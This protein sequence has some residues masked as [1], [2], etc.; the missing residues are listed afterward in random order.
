MNVSCDH[1]SEK[2]RKK[3]KKRKKKEKKKKEKK[4]K[5]KEKTFTSTHTFS[6]QSSQLGLK[7]RSKQYRSRQL[8]VLLKKEKKAPAAKKPRE[9]RKQPKYVPVYRV[10]RR[11]PSN[12]T[13][14]RAPK[15]RASLKPGAVVILL[16][17]KYQGRRVVL[18]DVLPSG[19]LLVS[20]PYRINGVPLRRVNPAYV[21][22]TT[23][24][25]DVSGVKLTDAMKSDAF[26]KAPAKAAGATSGGKKGDGEAFFAKKAKKAP[27]S[28]ERVQA[29][30]DVDSALEA[31]IKKTPLLAAYL[32]KPFSL[33]AGDRPHM[34]TF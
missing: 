21:M 17:G 31:A 9:K 13:K 27:L 6:V 34:M 32:R 2:R 11:A 20:G 26:F 10:P 12:R 16:A 29:Q 19:L 33:Q 3:R 14:H 25:V 18:L 1:G 23:T 28:A 5:K 22:A 15:V 7:S 30:K 24:S 8:H 4:K